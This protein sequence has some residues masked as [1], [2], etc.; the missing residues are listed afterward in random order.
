MGEDVLSAAGGVV[1]VAEVLVA[2]ADSGAAVSAVE[3]VAALEAFGLFG[4]GNGHGSPPGGIF[5]C[6]DLEIRWIDWISEPASQL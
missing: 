1:V 4:G 2:E 5:W 3:D 6:K